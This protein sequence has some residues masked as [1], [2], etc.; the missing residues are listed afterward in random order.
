M[1]RPAAH[2]RASGRGVDLP[3]VSS[4]RVRVAIIVIGILA[5]VVLEGAL[6]ALPQGYALYVV[7]LVAAPLAFLVLQQLP[8][9]SVLAIVMIGGPLVN[10]LVLPGNA[11]GIPPEAVLFVA[12][13]E[14]A[15]LVRLLRTGGRF[16]LRGVEWVY[17]GA[18]LF[19]LAVG[20]ASGGNQ[21]VIVAETIETANVIVLIL[22][23]RGLRFGARD[24]VT[25]ALTA[26][27]LLLPFLVQ[28][29]ATQFGVRR[30]DFY[31]SQIGSLIPLSVWAILGG[32]RTRRLPLVLGLMVLILAAFS[33]GQRGMM[34]VAVAGSVVAIGLQAFGASPGRQMLAVMFLGLLMVA[35]LEALPVLEQVAPA[36]TQRL[37][38]G[39]GAVSFERRI[40][41]AED[42]IAAWKSAPWGHGFGAELEIRSDITYEVL[43]PRL[44]AKSETF[45][46]NSYAWYLAKMGAQGLFAILLLLG[47]TVAV[48]LRGIM[49]GHPPMAMTGA[50]VI[51]VLS[52]GGAIG[53][54]A[55]HGF[56]YTSWVALAVVLATSWL[57]E[58]DVARPAPARVGGDGEVD[59]QSG[60]ASLPPHAPAAMPRP[61]A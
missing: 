4:T 8:V 46:H 32:P 58:A 12:F 28:Y 13:G 36:P 15:L 18:V 20:V 25:F 45:I 19:A 52:V 39:F 55:L 33:T 34:M 50:L 16:Q 3:S 41:E 27:L 35:L 60:L 44:I 59:P 29:L 2:P 9:G 43:G 6:L 24:A 51:L 54:P 48:G 23:L 11:E 42:A 38:E 30:I 22:I 56:Y 53:G 14:L 7:A 1:I 61:P 49:R 40:T 57:Y 21:R 10:Y 31:F 47:G 17:L 5:A 37:S 26:Q